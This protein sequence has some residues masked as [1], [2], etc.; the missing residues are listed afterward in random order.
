MGGNSHPGELKAH[1]RL[2]EAFLFS[3][4]NNMY[5]HPCISVDRRCKFRLSFV[6]VTAV[7]GSSCRYMTLS[8]SLASHVISF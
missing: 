7:R 3:F 4:L 5:R 2:R 8:G 6:W 1:Q